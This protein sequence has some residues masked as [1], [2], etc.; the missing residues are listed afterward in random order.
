MA[1]I[2]LSFNEGPLRELLVSPQGAVGKYLSKQALRVESAAKAICPV[3]TPES[4]G[5]PGYQ[6]GRLR[7]GIRWTPGAKDIDWPGICVQIVTD[8]GAAV[9]IIDDVDYAG[10]VHEG[11]R[12]MTGR[13]FM[14]TALDG[15]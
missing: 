5:H 6:G 9:T 1:D 2:Q 12:Y 8:S 13:P 10:F 15:L 4:T 14:T 11:T 7:A 3:G